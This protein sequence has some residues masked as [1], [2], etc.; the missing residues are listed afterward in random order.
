MEDQTEVVVNR[1]QKQIQPLQRLLLRLPELALEPICRIHV[2]V[3][4][5]HGGVSWFISVV[6]ETGWELY[7][8][9]CHRRPWYP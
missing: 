5:P 8:Y 1:S 9:Y 3:E 7:T 6:A 4:S 2:S